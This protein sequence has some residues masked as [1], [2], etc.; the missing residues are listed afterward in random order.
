MRIEIKKMG[1]NGEG[2]GYTPSNK[3]VFV[4]GVFVG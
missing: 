3:P 1:I 2:I 4:E